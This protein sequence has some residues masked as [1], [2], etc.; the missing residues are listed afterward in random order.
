MISSGNAILAIEGQ[1]RICPVLS[2]YRIPPFN[3]QA[4]ALEV[5]IAQALASV[6]VSVL[7]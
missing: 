2:E 5:A 1:L 7:S 4:I 3:Y 6:A